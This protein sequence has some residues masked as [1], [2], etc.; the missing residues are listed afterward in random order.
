MAGAATSEE[1]GI[2]GLMGFNDGNR[3]NIGNFEHNE[4]FQCIFAV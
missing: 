1:A 2:L 3:K 4:S